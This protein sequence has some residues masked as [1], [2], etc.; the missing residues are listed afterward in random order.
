MAQFTLNWFSVLV[1]INPNAIS[2]R[3]LYRQKSVGGAFISTGFTPAN[4]LPK[5]AQ[6]TTSPSLADNVIWEFKVQSICTEGGPTDNDNG[7]REHLHFAC[8]PPILTFTD[9]TATIVLNVTTTDITKAAFTLRQVSD[10]SVVYGPTISVRAGNSITGNATGLTPGTE[11]YWEIVLYTTIN[12]VEIYSTLPSNIDGP[13]GSE[14]FE[15][16]GA[17][18][19]PVTS[20]DVDSV[21]L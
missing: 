15:T 5:T 7:I 19:A 17:V 14:T 13:C 2:Q 3:A 18:C 1:M 8:I 11:Y 16:D 20:V 21:E 10:D 12:G 9:T 6:T 4:D